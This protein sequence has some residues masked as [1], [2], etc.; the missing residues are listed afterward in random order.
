MI[1]ALL[2]PISV[3]TNIMVIAYLRPPQT[4]T[5]SLV[6]GLLL[7]AA[8]IT[9]VVMLVGGGVHGFWDVRGAGI[10][11]ML[12]AAGGQIVAFITGLEVVRLAGA[13]YVSQMNYV[14]VGAG[15]LWA[16]ALFDEGLSAWIWAA[17]LVMLVGLG[18]TNLGAARAER[19]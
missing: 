16:L 10:W 5:V 11:A 1:V 14:I 2:V 6:C 4:S 9:F 19:G 15:F 18:F 12:W 7:S 8:A 17:L 13:V 3:A